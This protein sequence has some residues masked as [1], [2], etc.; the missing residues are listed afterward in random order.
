MREPFPSLNPYIRPR[1]LISNLQSLIYTFIIVGSNTMDS[2]RNKCC[3]RPRYW[4]KN[5]TT[6]GWNAL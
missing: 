1:P 6:E 2:V 5:V 4:W 3:V